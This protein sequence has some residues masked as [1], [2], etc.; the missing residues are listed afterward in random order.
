MFRCTQIKKTMVTAVLKGSYVPVRRLLW[1]PLI[2][3]VTCEKLVEHELVT[4]PQLRPASRFFVV[5]AVVEM[6]VVAGS[7][8]LEDNK[9]V[10]AGIPV[11][12]CSIVG[13]PNKPPVL[14]QR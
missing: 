6:L 4:L 13:L 11:L 12:L 2:L 8:Q 1:L 10:F 14:D 3:I 5:D 9:V 7:R